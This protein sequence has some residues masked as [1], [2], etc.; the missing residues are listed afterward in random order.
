MRLSRI[1]LGGV[2]IALALFAGGSAAAQ[3]KMP[4][5]KPPTAAETF[6]MH[7]D[8][9]VPTKVHIAHYYGESAGMDPSF[10]W[11]LSPI[12]SKFL[13]LLISKAKL[14]P[15]TSSNR[16][17]LAEY[18]WPSWWNRKQ[19]DALPEVYFSDASSGL[20]RVH[21]SRRSQHVYIEFINL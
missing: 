11:D 13:A 17:A 2:I 18:R 10:A 4:E 5:W 12:D 7:F 19:I 14:K 15:S 20:V 16:P 3:Q 6:E 8:C 21:V 9:K 1:N